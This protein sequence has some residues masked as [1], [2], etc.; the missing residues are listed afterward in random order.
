VIVGVLGLGL[1]G[2]GFDGTILVLGV[3]GYLIVSG[4]LGLSRRYDERMGLYEDSS[5]RSEADDGGETTS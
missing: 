5:D 3:F 1:D 2:D 4:F